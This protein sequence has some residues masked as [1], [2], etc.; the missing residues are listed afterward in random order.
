[1]CQDYH[2]SQAFV[3]S[4]CLPTPHEMLVCKRDKPGSGLL[5]YR[6][7]HQR[8]ITSHVAHYRA[9]C[10]TEAGNDAGL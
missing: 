9:S 8:I 2:F 4:S 1:M 6:K 3:H 7:I 5:L 10:N